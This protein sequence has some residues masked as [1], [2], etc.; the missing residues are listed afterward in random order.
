MTSVEVEP[1]VDVTDLDAL[2]GKHH[3]WCETC[4]PAWAASP[5]N[6]APLG[7][8]FTAWCGAR[9]VYLV[10]WLSDGLPPGPLCAA[11]W[12]EPVA[13]CATCGTPQ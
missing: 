2:D 9:A 4:H 10:V 5:T 13:P 6:S 7:V 3:A 8:P 11:C 1:E 12:A